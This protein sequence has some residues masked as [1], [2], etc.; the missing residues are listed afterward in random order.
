MSN[1]FDD[2][3]MMAISVDWHDNNIVLSVVGDI[4]MLTA[5]T[6][7]RIGHCSATEQACRPRRR[8]D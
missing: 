3:P 7:G 1:G 6:T 5:L 2:R 8:F 4:D